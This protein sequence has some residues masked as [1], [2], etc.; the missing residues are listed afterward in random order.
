MYSPVGEAAVAE[1]VRA[2]LKLPAAERVAYLQREVA[3]IGKRHGEVYNTMVREAVAA[4]LG[5]PGL[6]YWALEWQPDWV[7]YEKEQR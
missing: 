3:R 7:S 5:D 2:A 4:A 6:A 1:M